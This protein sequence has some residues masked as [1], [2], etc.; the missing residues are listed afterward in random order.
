[1]DY[2][3]IR[4]DKVEHSAS[5]DKNVRTSNASFNEVT[6]INN[7]SI[8]ERQT[9]IKRFGYQSSSYFS[10]QQGVDHVGIAGTGFIAFYSQRF[11]GTTFN[12]AFTNPICA[13]H[14]IPHLLT[15]LE[16]VTGH[17]TIFMAVD[18]QCANQLIEMGYSCND[19]GLE[20]HI[21]IADYKIEGK[22][23]KYLRWAANLGKRGFTVKE[24]VWDEIDTEQVKHIS[25]L[26]RHTKAV[27]DK[28]LRLITR[29]PEFKDAWEVRKFFCYY[30][31]DLV[32]YVFF[33]PYFE[34]EE[35]IGYT[36]NIL[37]GRKDIHP[38]GF[39]DFTL[40]EAMNV[41]R[42]EGVPVLSLGISPLHDIAPHK[43]EIK[44]VRLLQKLM[45]RYGSSIYAFQELAYHKS[46][47]RAD[48]TMWFQCVPPNSSAFKAAAA[49]LIAINVF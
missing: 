38:N 16:Q 14:D 32:G 29:P 12:I 13:P 48:S 40:L 23:M 11:L 4:G 37:R 10:L 2:S 30:E 42:D 1:M 36:A 21:P 28:E 39:L 47:Y 7:L 24:Q 3:V 20:Y 45:Y 8:E 25:T 17:Q 33:D 26:W 27:K 31:G 5:L 19:M 34:N 49:V 43:K 35:L 6:R 41:F 9:L 22:K 18:Q 44:W 46:R 15:L